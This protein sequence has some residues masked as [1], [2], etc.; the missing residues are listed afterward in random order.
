[1]SLGVLCDLCGFFLFVSQREY[2]LMPLTPDRVYMLAADHRW[3]WEEF[4]DARA[5]P[6]ERISEVKRLAFDAFL[7]ARE[8]SAAVRESGALLVDQQYSSAVIAEAL[9]TGLTV[10][11]PA[12]KAGAVP[13]AWATEPFSAALTG[14]FAKVLARY[15]SD[16]DPA[17]LAEQWA[18]LE[19]LQAWCRGA[20]KPFVLEVLVARKQEPEDGFEASGR[21]AMLAAF[22]AEAYRRGLAPEFWKIEGTLAAQGARTID[23]AIAANPSCRQII[24]GKAAELSTI[25]RWFSACADSATATGFAIGRSVFWEP[26]AAYL[27][28]AKTADH[29]AAMI[30]DNY[31]HLVGAWERSRQ[32]EI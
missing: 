24:L 21:P 26:S 31:L 4:C 13:L 27:T 12:E 3:Q 23:A 14:A 25:D 28:G 2:P 9:Q 29:A 32:S 22:I 19:A 18:K 1:M 6:R 5:L 11:T 15:R 7:R 8:Q 10:G 16:D 20:G 30:C 17:V